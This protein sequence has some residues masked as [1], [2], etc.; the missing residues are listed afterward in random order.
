MKYIFV[1][2]LLLATLATAQ[3]PSDLIQ[4]APFP[5]LLSL[6]G[7]TAD[8]AKAI[9]ALNPELGLRTDW[10]IPNIGR[11]VSWRVDEMQEDNI[12]VP[13]ALLNFSGQAPMNLSETS[14]KADSGGN[15]TIISSNFTG[16][17]WT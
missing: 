17:I 2:L 6:S 14:V 8:S 9:D 10:E 16:M 15:A 11:Y 5:N 13:T 1:A 12:G 7:T 4:K 3:L